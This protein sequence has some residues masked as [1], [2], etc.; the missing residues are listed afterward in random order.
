VSAVR[1]VAILLVLGTVPGALWV[2]GYLPPP[3]SPEAAAQGSANPGLVEAEWRDKVQAICAWER[4]RVQSITKAF[5]RVATPAD[6][7]L[8]FDSTIRLGRTSLAIFRRLETPF[9][10]QREARDV[11]RVLEREQRALVGLREALRKGNGRAFARHAARIA[12]AEERK[13][14]LFADLGLRGCLPRAP[15]RAPEI[16]ASPV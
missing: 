12:Q 1:I 8:V 10:F 2:A 11:E 4:K 14:A 13:R 9:A 6:A 5:R 15:E 16:D 7:L 3:S